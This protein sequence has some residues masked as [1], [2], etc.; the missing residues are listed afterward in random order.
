MLSKVEIQK[1]IGNRIRELR[2]EKNI[3]Q[4]DLAGLCNME[5][6]N[7]SR[8]EAGRSNPTIYTLA[9]IADKLN[10][11]LKELISF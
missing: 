4:Q 10:I 1:A 7:F 2:E 8:I 6:S 3:P 9:L 11:S 5:K